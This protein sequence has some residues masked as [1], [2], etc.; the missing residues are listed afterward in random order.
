MPERKKSGYCRIVVVNAEPL[1]RVRDD[2]RPSHRITIHVC[3]HRSSGPVLVDVEF[4]RAQLSWIFMCL[5][6]GQDH[7]MLTAI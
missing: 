3:M 1:D 5:G 4:C 2:Y 6:T 7:Q